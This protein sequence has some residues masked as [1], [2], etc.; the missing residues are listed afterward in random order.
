MKVLPEAFTCVESVQLVRS[1]L[2]NNLNEFEEFQLDWVFRRLKSP[3]RKM[4]LA[5]LK[6]CN[7]DSEF[8]D[9]TAPMRPLLQS[10]KLDLYQQAG[11]LP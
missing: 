1:I 4:F 10:D 6:G 7:P 3:Q 5:M 8:L 11:L 2:D 9:F